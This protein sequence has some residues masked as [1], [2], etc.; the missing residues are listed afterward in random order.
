MAARNFLH[1]GVFV[2]IGAKTVNIAVDVAV[3]Y[4]LSTA[5]ALIYAAALEHEAMLWTQD[6]HFAGLPS[7]EYFEKYP[8]PAAA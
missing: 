3:E 1:T 5:D 2:E 7:V 4:R 8:K 6:K